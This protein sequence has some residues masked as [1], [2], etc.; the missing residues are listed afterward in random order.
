MAL[1]LSIETATSVCSVALHRD[2]QLLS[3]KEIDSDKSHSTMLLQFVAD[4]LTESGEN[5]KHLDAIAVSEGPGSYTGLRIGLSTAKGLCF[6]LEKPLIAINTLDAMAFLAFDGGKE[7]TLY[8]P[9][10]DARRM[11]VYTA[12][13][14]S[15]YNRVLEPCAKVVDE[16]SF[17]KELAENSV[18]FL[19]NGAEKCKEVLNSDN[20]YFIDGLKPSAVT[21]GQL[22]FKKY[23]A[24]QFEDVAYFE[25][26]YLKEFYTPP[27]KKNQM[28]KNLVSKS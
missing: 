18:V 17:A 2:G 20:A 15:N 21:I 23:T 6:A 26:N 7:N 9:M 14:N 13:Y 19:G 24:K 12:L 27:P 1:I 8:A 5:K 3:V 10:I 16:N 25:P 22:A 11:E 28:L 4:V